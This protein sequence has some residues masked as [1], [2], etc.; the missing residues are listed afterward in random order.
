MSTITKL[1]REN[2]E[3]GLNDNPCFDKAHKCHD[4]RNHIPDEIRS[5][6]KEMTV[7]SRVVTYLMAVKKANAENWD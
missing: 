5:V 7:E 1:I 4:W 2:R 6:W 3:V